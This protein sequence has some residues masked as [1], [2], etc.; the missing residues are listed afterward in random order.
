MIYFVSNGD[1]DSEQTTKPNN[2][3][4]RL[5]DN[6]LIAAVYLKFSFNLNDFF[7]SG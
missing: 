3:Y 6:M 5:N 4:K 1:H 7:F 2:I